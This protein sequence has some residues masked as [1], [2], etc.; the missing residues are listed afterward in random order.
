MVGAGRSNMLFAK[1]RVMVGSSKAEVPRLELLSLGMCVCHVNTF[2]LGKL[3]L[4][5][6]VLSS[7]RSNQLSLPS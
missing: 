3:V 7:R 5:S 1:V 6:L 2:T 4:H